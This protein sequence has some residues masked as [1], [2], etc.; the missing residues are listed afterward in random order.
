MWSHMIN[1]CTYMYLLKR[2]TLLLLYNFSVS[3]FCFFCFCLHMYSSDEV[4][5]F[6]LRVMEQHARQKHAYSSDDDILAFRRELLSWLQP[7]QM[8]RQGFIYRILSSGRKVTNICISVFVN[9]H[10]VLSM[11]Y[12]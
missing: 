4:K 5:F 2:N 9:M 11:T 12:H 6:S 7:L 8:V 1:T 10:V 3:I